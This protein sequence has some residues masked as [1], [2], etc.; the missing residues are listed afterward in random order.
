MNYLIFGSSYNLVDVEIEKILCGRKATS[1]SL[2]EVN[3]KEILEDLGYSSMFEEEKVI[4]LKNFEVL[5]SSKKDNEKDL[6][7]LEEYLKSPNEH[8]TIIFTSNEKIASKGALKGIISK[9]KVIETPVITKLF[10]L[11]KLF[12]EYIRKSGYGISQSVLNTFCEKCASNYDIAINEFKKLVQIKKGNTLITD[13]DVEEYVANYNLTDEFG[14]KD[15]VIGLNVSKAMAMIDDLEA[16]KTPIVKIVVTIA[17]EYQAV[18]NIK[19]LAAKKMTNDQI[20][21]EMGGMHPYRVKLLREAGNKY[22][23]EKL[24]HLILYLCNLE[25]K[26]VSEDNLEFDE[27]RKF[28]LEL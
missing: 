14:F 12:G 15:A 8:T 5:N 28:L 23:L 16:S 2:E 6:K 7:S 13:E 22:S 20:S 4:I 26:L 11:T 21:A 18:Y 9:L 19:L 24:E 10:E 1:Y 3:L 25:L 17:K 27:L